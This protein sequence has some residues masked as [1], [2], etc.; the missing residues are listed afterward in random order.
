MVLRKYCND[1]FETI[2]KMNSF[3]AITIKYHG[4]IDKK[5]VIC[6][7]DK[8]EKLIGAGYLKYDKKFNRKGKYS[9]EFS[10][11]LDEEHQG[12]VEIDGMLM[13]GLIKRYNEIK[14]DNPQKELCLRICC[15]TNEINDMQFFLDKGFSLN[16]V[17]PV[18]KYNLLQETNHYNIPDN[19]QIKEYSFSEENLQ[20]YINADFEASGIPESKADIQFKVGDPN[21]KCFVAT[22]DS[23]VVGAISV[24]NITD[25]RAA[26]ENIFVIP[27]FRRKNISR[28]LIATAFDE[29]K[30]RGM[31][32]ATLSMS[33]TN[34]RAMKLYLSCCY[35][36]YYNLIEMVYDQ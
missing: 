1:N 32:I 31:E 20:N 19:V 17:I 15:E 11:L 8:D 28:E 26:T 13:D 23:K 6:V 10:T 9:I 2:K 16:S 22:C 12:N 4:D 36:L 27:S 3:F 24:W 7:V 35:S 5:D 25:K 18:L 21:F 29:L 33:G 30:E 14:N 34:L